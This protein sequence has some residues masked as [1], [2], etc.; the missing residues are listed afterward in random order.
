MRFLSLLVLTLI[1]AVESASWVN[2]RFQQTPAVSD[3]SEESRTQLGLSQRAQATAFRPTFARYTPRTVRPRYSNQ[4]TTRP[5]TRT[6]YTRPPTRAYYTRPPTRT[7]YTR[8]ATSTSYTRPATPTSYTRPP[9]RAYY[10][11][12]S[13]RTSYA[14]PPARTSYTRPVA[15]TSYVRPAYSAYRP[16]SPRPTARPFSYQNRPAILSAYRATA[17]A[18]PWAVSS[19]TIVPIPSPQSLSAISR[20]AYRYRPR[21]SSAAYQRAVRFNYQM[22]P[23]VRPITV[24]RSAYSQQPNYVRPTYN[25]RRR[26]TSYRPRP[27]S[28]RPRPRY[29]RARQRSTAT[30]SPQLWGVNQAQR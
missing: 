17:T 14:R 21:S 24:V 26:P 23:T 13:T 6:S 10:T 2:S 30:A 20:P 15:R 16:N 22:I 29:Y 9:T 3:S 18:K 28:Y 19:P 25:Y 7:S 27:T 11:R 8:P 1:V 12:P 4:P 5:P